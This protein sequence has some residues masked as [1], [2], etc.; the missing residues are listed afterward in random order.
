M[1]QQSRL[2]QKRVMGGEIDGWV[3]ERL[4]G[5]HYYTGKY[6]RWM[7]SLYL[8]CTWMLKYT[9]AGIS[10]TQKTATCFFRPII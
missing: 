6:S 2:R 5:L 8:K 1:E 4:N 3:A 9:L 7:A 10:G